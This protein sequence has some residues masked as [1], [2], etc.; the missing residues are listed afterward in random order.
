VWQIG[1]NLGKKKALIEVEGKVC[2]LKRSIIS[3]HV[4]IEESD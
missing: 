3:D 1:D 2:I 4:W